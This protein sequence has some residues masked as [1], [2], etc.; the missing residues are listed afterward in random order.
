MPV[1][2]GHPGILSQWR[3]RS[4]PVAGESVSASAFG[5]ISRHRMQASRNGQ[6]ASAPGREAMQR[7]AHGNVLPSSEKSSSRARALSSMRAVAI[8]AAPVRDR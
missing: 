6:A 5:D 2:G 4:A 8:R 3:E 1:H 7:S